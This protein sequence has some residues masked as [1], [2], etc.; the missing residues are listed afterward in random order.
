[1]TESIAKRESLASGVVPTRTVIFDL[2]DTLI[3]EEHTAHASMC[4]ALSLIPGFEHENARP[5]AAGAIREVW[6]SGPEHALC[7]SLGIASWEALWATFEGCHPILDGVRA[8]LPTYRARA[9][10][11]ALRSLGATD[12]KLLSLVSET[13]IAAQLRGH[14]LVD[15]ASSVVEALATTHQLGLLTNGPSDIQRRKL[16]GTGLADRFDAVTISGDIGVGK[17]SGAAFCH[18]LDQLGARAED[19]TMVGDSWERD[20]LGA[21]AIGMSAV[22]IGDEPGR[23]L[24]LERVTVVANVGALVETID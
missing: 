8:W 16:E 24:D 23:A 18:V 14:P 21:T 3:V 6:H 20:V 7:R 12:P 1:V 22:W 9:W 17:P 4:E 13:Y 19:A 10:S 11:A 5:V 15:G 2:D